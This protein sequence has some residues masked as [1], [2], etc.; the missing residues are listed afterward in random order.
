VSYSLIRL[1][2]E[3]K[4]FL[5]GIVAVA[6]SSLLALFEGGLL[7]GQFSLTSTPID[8]ASA[9]IWVGHSKNL[10]LD[11]SRPI[12]ERWLNIVAV[13]PE[14]ERAECYIIRLF[15]LQPPHG[16]TGLCTVVGSSLEDDAIGAVREL[17]PELRRLLSEPGSVVADET[18]LGRL[19]FGGIG[20]VAEVLS[21]RRVRL[22][23]VVRDL[24]SLAAPYLFC[25]LETAGILYDDIEDDQT[26]YILARCRTAASASA[27]VRRLRREP[28]LS[29][30]TS[31]DLATS[32]RVRWM[33]TT[34]AGIT[35][36]WSALLGLLIGLVITC[37]T[38]YAATA[39]AW[40]EYAVLEALGIPTWRMAAT[41]LAQ[42]FWIGTVGLAVAVPA[43]LGLGRLLEFAGT[44]MLFPAW[45]VGPT[46][47]VTMATVLVSGL[48]ALRSLRL[49]QPAELLR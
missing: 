14:V 31:S 22:V 12:P 10:S 43:S 27:V 1:V 17:T 48:F 45:L 7:V 35:A 40:R 15:M 19:G 34:K 18:E 39:A 38:L 33:T 42:S 46:L 16:E 36:V 44:R 26:I 21:G 13:Q 3:R 41:V 20:D 11:L 8:H 9:D 49:A 4:R 5:P 25:S 23:G 29:V 47:A 32:T 6:F 2:H 24:K 30:S 37:Q 28:Y